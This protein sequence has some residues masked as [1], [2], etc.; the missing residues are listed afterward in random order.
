MIANTPQRITQDKGNVHR[1]VYWDVV[2]G[3]AIL[4]VVAG[5]SLQY[6]TSSAAFY[7]D[8]IFKFIYGF[9]MPLLMM[10]SGFWFY[11]SAERHTPLE[12]F[13]VRL[14]HLILP[15]LTF[16]LVVEFSKLNFD[17]RSLLISFS[18]NLWFLWA[19]FWLSCAML[20]ARAVK[21]DDNVILYILLYV[22]TF[23]LPIIH[24][25]YVYLFMAPFFV[26]GYLMNKKGIFSLLFDRYLIPTTVIST[27][28][29]LVLLLFFNRETYIYDSHFTFLDGGGWRQILINCQRT[30]TGLCGSFM[31]LGLIRLCNRHACTPI[32]CALQYLG[33]N[34]LQIYVISLWPIFSRLELMFSNNDINYLLA[35][36]SFIVCIVTTI[37]IVELLK[38]VPVTDF[39][40]FGAKMRKQSRK[41]ES[42]DITLREH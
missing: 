11:N 33:K 17:P 24:F 32:K 42:I 20:L 9:H 27:L 37:I 35:F 16:T 12:V 41:T 5:H 3:I 39:L 2:R 19:T 18:Y 21:C 29:Y 13:K 1:S 10:I 31:F 25:S 6:S 36:L 4:L 7:N 38:A 28:L 8:P 26:I 23:F 22:G 15:V 40:F 30:I 34:T 14:R